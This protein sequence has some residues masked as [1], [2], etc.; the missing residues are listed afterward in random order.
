MFSVVRDAKVFDINVTDGKQGRNLCESTGFI[1]NINVETVGFLDRSARGVDK[2]I[3]VDSGLVEEIVQFVS[4]MRLQLGT[5]LSQGFDVFC[6]QLLDVVRVGQTNLLPHLGGRGGYSGNILKSSGRNHFH[7]TVLGIAV[8]YQIH[9]GSGNDMGKMA[10]GCSHIVML[11]VIQDDG[12]SVQIGNKLPVEGKLLVRNA[13]GRRQDVVCIFQK[14]CLGIAVACT[15]TACQGMSAEKTVLQSGW[16]DGF[17]DAGVY[18]ADIRQKS[19]G[20]L[21]FLHKQKI[22]IIFLNGCA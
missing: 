2:G 13:F 11:L 17:V 21:K 3:T 12:E 16:L 20:I 6:E 14:L 4:L 5:N 19:V 22:I 1:C 9:Q 10:D 18:T 8:L 7:D 15:L